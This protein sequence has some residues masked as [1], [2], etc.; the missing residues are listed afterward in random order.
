MK[1]IF[2][3]ANAKLA[4]LEKRTGKRVVTFSVLSGW[5]CPYAKECNS[6]AVEVDGKRTI[7][8]GPHTQFRCFSASQEA[9][10]KGV[11][12][13]RKANGELIK[14]AA[15]SPVDAAQCIVENIPKK[16]KIVR[17][18][19]GGDFQTKS[20]FLAWTLAAIE[21]PDIVFYAYTKSLPFWVACSNSIPDNFILTASYGGYRDDL[22]TSHNL[23]SAK[24]VFSKSEAKKL[25]LKIDH[26]DF[27][28]YNPKKRNESFALLLHGVQPKG[29]EAAKAL[30]KLDGVG[31]YGKGGK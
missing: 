24:V 27:H 26:D 12:N 28:A 1:L 17:I 19:V 20:Y 7:L 11:Y 2:G 15:L 22:I 23:R 30:S 8:D 4:G 14:L 3:K 6:K 29:S 10:F 18:H 31:S 25:G 5:T 16:A 21:R 9:L 13:S